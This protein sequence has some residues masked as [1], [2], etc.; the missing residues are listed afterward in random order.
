MP[1]ADCR[2]GLRDLGRAAAS[3]IRERDQQLLVR[4]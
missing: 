1:A 4:R 3:L 2:A